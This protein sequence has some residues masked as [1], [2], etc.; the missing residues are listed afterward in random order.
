[1]AI[2]ITKQDSVRAY[3]VALLSDAACFVRCIGVISGYSKAGGFF[4]I[5]KETNQALIGHDHSDRAASKTRY[6]AVLVPCRAMSKVS[7]DRR[8]CCISVIDAERPGW[9]MTHRDGYI[10]YEPE[11]APRSPDTF[12][13]DT[14]FCLNAKGVFFPGFSTLESVSLPNHFVHSTAN[15]KV[16][17]SLMQNTQEFHESASGYSI[18]RGYKGESPLMT[19]LYI[20][21]YKHSQIC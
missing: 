20:Y 15:D 19:T 10:F 13:N 1:M 2:S 8:R 3:C 16:A 7:P 9:Y 6:G 11:Y 17:L 21:M 12:D 5:S 14:S 4:Y 18:Q